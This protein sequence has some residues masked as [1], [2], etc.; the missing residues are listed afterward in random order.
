MWY[1]KFPYLIHTPQSSIALHYETDCELVPH[2]ITP[3]GAIGRTTF[4]FQDNTD[5][6]EASREAR[7]APTKK[8]FLARVSMAANKVLYPYI[9]RYAHVW[10]ETMNFAKIRTADWAH[11]PRGITVGAFVDAWLDKARII[12]DMSWEPD[13]PDEALL[14]A[15][16]TAANEV[17]S[18]LT[19]S[20]AQFHSKATK[21]D[22]SR[23]TGANE[24]RKLSLVAA[25]QFD[26][27]GEKTAAARMRALESEIVTLCD[28]NPL[29]TFR[30]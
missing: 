30:G 17:K 9:R 28:H 10:E 11:F 7:A 22:L 8:E 15:F 21:V 13:R 2:F 3:N 6:M 24:L 18:L 4:D 14:G 19:N 16:T 1:G 25:A 27:L 23:M 29:L 26:R 20:G 12:L 5:L